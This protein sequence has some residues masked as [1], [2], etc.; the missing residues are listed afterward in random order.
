MSVNNVIKYFF[1]NRLGIA[2]IYP[3]TNLVIQ[4]IIITARQIKILQRVDE[5]FI[6]MVNDTVGNVSDNDI[7]WILALHNLT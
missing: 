7:L 4:K 6:A 2:D 5:A 3:F 1:I